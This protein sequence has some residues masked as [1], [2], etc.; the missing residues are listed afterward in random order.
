M[1]TLAQLRTRAR[2]R[3]DMELGSG[4]SATDH[5]ITNTELNS[6]INASIAELYDLLVKAYDAD[7]YLT[8][9]T[10]TGVASTLEYS[11][12]NDFYKMKGLD[13]EDGTPVKKFL[14]AKRNN[15]G[16]K[17]RLRSSKL[18]FSD[19]PVV[20]EVFTLWYIPKPTELSADADT[21]DGINGWEEYV[22]VD[23]AIKMRTKEETDTTDLKMEKQALKSRIEDM[24][25]D[26]DTGEPERIAD[27]RD[28]SNVDSFGWEMYDE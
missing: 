16:L 22:I 3:A 11:L 17:Y 20:G 18:R 21:F 25:Q 23:A 7:Y 9:S 10:V 2:E 19:Y 8:S 12:P 6:Y 27:V 1:A 13:R 24:S 5:F 4:Q 26:R 14:F 28:N 15:G